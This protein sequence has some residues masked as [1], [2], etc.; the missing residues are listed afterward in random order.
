SC[1]AAAPHLKEP[2]IIEAP[3]G[4]HP[5]PVADSSVDLYALTHN[6]TSTGVAMPVRRPKGA[7]LPAHGGG[8]VAVDGTS[9]AGGLRV[10]ATEFDAYYLAPQKCFASDGGLWIA[11]LLPA[12]AEG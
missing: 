3:V 1:A 11:L 8:L 4:T 10:E 2:Q 12:W 5:T 9:G 6:E 7:E